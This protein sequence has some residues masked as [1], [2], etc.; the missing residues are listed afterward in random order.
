ME[1]LILGLILVAL[2]VYASTRIKRSA[3]QAFEQEPIETDEFTLIKPAGFLHLINGDPAYKFQAYSKEFGT[4]NAS[5]RR[6]AT[7][8][9]CLISDKTLENVCEEAKASGKLL[10]A[11]NFQFDEMKSCSM[12]IERSENG[13]ELNDRFF[14]VET[15]RGVYE[16]RTSVLK[17]HIAV[18]SRKI[19]EMEGSL[20]IKK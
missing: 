5:N 20:T 7:V 15:G 13:I 1:I 16:L 9:L 11:K 3:A 18:L 10:S 17:D 12:E 4:E 2:M 8:D 14:I 19:D 6:Q